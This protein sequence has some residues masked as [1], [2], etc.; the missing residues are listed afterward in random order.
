MPYLQPISR[1]V[2]SVCESVCG[3]NHTI[4]HIIF[5]TDRD[6]GLMFGM[7]TLQIKLLVNATTYNDGIPDIYFTKAIIY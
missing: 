4:G 6:N 7:Y 3:K 2:K 5:F 1:S